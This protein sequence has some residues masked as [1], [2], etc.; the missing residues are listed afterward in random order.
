MYIIGHVLLV[1]KYSQ[2]VC[3]NYFPITG[4]RGAASSG[5]EEETHDEGEKNSWEERSVTSRTHRDETIG[6]GTNLAQI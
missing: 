2:V 5:L 4:R 1:E 3:Y 6:A